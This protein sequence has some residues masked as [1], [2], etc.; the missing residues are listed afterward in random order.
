MRAPDLKPVRDLFMV[1][2][3]F[4]NFRFTA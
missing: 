4:S 1:A 3:D 2:I